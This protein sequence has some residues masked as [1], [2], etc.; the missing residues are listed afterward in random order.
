[1]IAALTL[2]VAIVGYELWPRDAAR[3]ERLLEETASAL[4]RTHDEASLAE[5]Q[6]FLRA[7]LLPTAT[8]RAAELD[9]ELEGIDAVTEQ[10]RELLSGPPLKFSWS[11]IDVTVSGRLA[12]VD[13]DLVVAVRGGAEQ[14]Q[15]SRRARVRLVKRDPGWQIEA[16]EVDAIVP[17]E[18]EA[19]P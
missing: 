4:N 6:T 19:R 11:S 1:M 3:I 18:P 2:L 9:R 5:L 8:V 12:S 13:A 15:Q 7:A 10:A 16:V 17:S 14:R